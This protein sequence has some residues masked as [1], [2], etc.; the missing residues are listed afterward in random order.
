[1]QP[2]ALAGTARCISPNNVSFDLLFLVY[3]LGVNFQRLDDDNYELQR[4][5]LK[6]SPAS[7]AVRRSP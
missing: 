5:R 6:S 7:S 3:F 2:V 1:M 4:T